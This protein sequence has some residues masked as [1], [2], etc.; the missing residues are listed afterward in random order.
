MT[1][2]IVY[3]CQSCIIVLI[4]KKDK[5]ANEKYDQEVGTA[6]FSEESLLLVRNGKYLSIQAPSQPVDIDSTNDLVVII[7]TSDKN[8]VTKNIIIREFQ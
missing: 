6:Q 5:K 4:N 3:L 8:D 1:L 7:N 2:L